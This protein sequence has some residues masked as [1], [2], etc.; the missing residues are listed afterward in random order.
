MEERGGRICRCFRICF[1]DLSICR[2]PTKCKMTRI[3]LGSRQT[4]VELEERHKALPW[5]EQPTQ[6]CGFHKDVFP[7]S[8]DASAR[9]GRGRKNLGWVAEGKKLTR[10]QENY[11]K[12]RYLH[13][14]PILLK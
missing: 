11:C 1:T 5:G 13:L 12:V 6:P 14:S 7:V 4:A 9:E 8:E 2:S 10:E 3:K